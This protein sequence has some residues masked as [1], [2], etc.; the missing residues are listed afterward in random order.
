MVLEGS[1]GPQKSQMV[2]GAEIS[3]FLRKR[4]THSRIEAMLS[5]YQVIYKQ[6]ITSDESW[7]Y[8]YDP[9]T[10]DQYYTF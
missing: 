2:F 4:A 1:F 10:T 7:I 3:H 9:E 5:D 8:A 6:I